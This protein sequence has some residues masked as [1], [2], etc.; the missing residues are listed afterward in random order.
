M[1]EI[2]ATG[3]SVLNN[4]FVCNADTT[5][6]AIVMSGSTGCLI[7]GNSANYGKTAM[8]NEC[9]VDSDSANCWGNNYQGNTYALPA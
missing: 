3:A 5:G 2:N 9:Y 8:V 6:A 4:V 7:D 1:R